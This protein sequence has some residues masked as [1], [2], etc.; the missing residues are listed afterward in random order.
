MTTLHITGNTPAAIKFIEYARSLP[1][2]KE[3]A[4]DRAPGVPATRTE[5]VD[6]LRLV[7]AEHDPVACIAHSQVIGNLEKQIEGWK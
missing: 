5:L 1:F 3:S 2:V 7:E 4:F 6:E